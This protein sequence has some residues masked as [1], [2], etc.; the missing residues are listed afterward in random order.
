M[1]AIADWGTEAIRGHFAVSVRLVHTSTD[2]LSK[3][4]RSRGLE[5]IGQG[6]SPRC[7]AGDMR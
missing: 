3:A 1:R 6:Q 7:G 2:A 4:T 5:L